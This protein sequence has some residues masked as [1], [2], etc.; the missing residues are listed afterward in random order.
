MFSSQIIESNE[1]SISLECKI[2][3]LDLEITVT[4]NTITVNSDSLRTPITTNLKNVRTNPTT[5]ELFRGSLCFCSA[6]T[7][8]KLSRAIASSSRG[9]MG[10]RLNKSE[11]EIAN[12]VVRTLF[13][14]FPNL[15]KDEYM[16]EARPLFKGLIASES[17]IKR[18]QKTSNSK[19]LS[20][21]D[22]PTIGNKFPGEISM[23]M[24]TFESSINKFLKAI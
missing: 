15:T 5:R 20:L 13:E 23:L 8:S 4:D 16:D 10:Y 9:T 14:S 18:E 22:Y 3:K 24:C 11:I 7:K 17:K 1:N 2:T 19:I 12:N 6:E 21:L